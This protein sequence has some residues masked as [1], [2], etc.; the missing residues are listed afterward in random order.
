LTE[1]GFN[2][3]SDSRFFDKVEAC[4]DAQFHAFC[5]GESLRGGRRGP[6]Y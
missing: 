1:F 4:G 5:I 3:G 6:W 2:A